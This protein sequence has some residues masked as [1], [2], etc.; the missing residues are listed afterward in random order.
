MHMQSS[1]GPLV[2]YT[3]FIAPADTMSLRH[4][5]VKFPPSEGAVCCNLAHC[6]EVLHRGPL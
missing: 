1:A 6:Q 4:H 5:A 2:L 3:S